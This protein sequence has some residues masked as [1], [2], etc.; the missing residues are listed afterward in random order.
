MQKIVKMDVN[1]MM[2]LHDCNQRYEH[3]QSILI[4]GPEERENVKYSIVIPTYKRVETLKDA[5]RSSLNQDGEYDYNIIVV[6]NNPTRDDET[7]LFIKE[8][9]C[10]KKI[11]YYKNSSNI[12]MTANMNRCIELCEGEFAVLLHDDDILFP[13]YLS[14][15]SNIVI[16]HPEIDILYVGLKIWHQNRNESYP[17]VEISNKRYPLYKSSLINCLFTN[18]HTPTGMLIRKES[19]LSVGG[20]DEKTY[21]SQDYYFYA[22]AT[23]NDLKVYN[24][25]KP[26]VIYRKYINE[27]LNE[28]TRFS[29]IIITTPLHRWLTEKLC[30]KSFV[31]R[32]LLSVK[33]NTALIPF[34]PE[35][36]MLASNYGIKYSK[37]LLLSNG[38]FRKVLQG[39]YNLQLSVIKRYIYRPQT[40]VDI[41]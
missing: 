5:I 6:D 15:I 7:E 4:Y 16:R 33:V 19:F 2:A 37:L 39:Y 20:F 30:I 1:E 32:W 21:P 24:Y 40:V 31:K 12:G 41:I 11:K 25:T 34:R 22:Y 26:I 8:L 3:V 36:I 35:T 10:P 29:F 9:G 23:V 18:N 13:D 27:S 14:S 28:N 17:S 38:L